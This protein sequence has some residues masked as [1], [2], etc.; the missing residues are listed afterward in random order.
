[1]KICALV[2]IDTGIGKSVAV[3]LLGKYLLEQ[4][5]AVITQKLVQTGCEK[6]AEDIMTHRRL[7][8][9]EWTEFD[10]QGL[11]CPYL[12][13][14][15]ASPHLAADIVGS[16]IE[17]KILTTATQKLTSHFEVVLIEGTGGVLVPLTRE[18]TFLDYLA[19]RGYPLILVTSSRLGS[20][21]HTLLSL[22]AIQTR[23]LNLLGII[24]NMYSNTPKEIVRDTRVIIRDYL[25]EYFPS[26]GIADMSQCE[27]G[28]YCL[29]EESFMALKRGC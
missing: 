14:F 24:Y 28:S 4:G 26:A 1:M 10:D 8:G 19:D 18:L 7:M 22:L 16:R 21:N 9:M 6:E 27:D 15:P 23:K 12:F 13:P 5:R 11:T 3:G 25:T 17:T 2:G 20:I 29:N